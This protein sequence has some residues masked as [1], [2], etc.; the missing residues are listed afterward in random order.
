MKLG[1]KI[2]RDI[3]SAMINL[4]QI[5]PDVLGIL[6]RSG[7]GIANFGFV[8]AKETWPTII[9]Y[10]EIN[11]QIDQL[12]TQ[13]SQE[14][15]GNGELKRIKAELLDGD[16][17]RVRKIAEVVKQGKCILFLGPGALQFN[18]NGVLS[19][20][21]ESL[22]AQLCI[23]LNSPS[24]IYYDEA[25]KKDLRYIVQRYEALP[26][27]VNGEIGAKAVSHFQNVQPRIL[28][29]PFQ[30][31]KMM[32]FKLIINTNADDSF[33]SVVNTT[34]NSLCGNDYYDFSNDPEN[35]HPDL[36]K[37]E[38]V[39][40]NI[41]GSLKYPHSILFT[42]ADYVRFSKNILQKTPPL[43]LRVINY[44]DDSQYYL[45]LVFQFSAWHL[46]ILMEALSIVKKDERSVSVY[47]DKPLSHHE[48]EYY[49][50]EF[51]FHFLDYDVSEFTTI[52]W[53]EYQKI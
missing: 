51:K 30:D 49:D 31:L 12:I 43:P 6:K 22:A 11:Q 13:A 19:T 41:F 10:A 36:S 48:F 52:L 27:Y 42:E 24:G 33:S 50:K 28:D 34:N 1:P 35:Q 37:F 45:F 38:K 23:K 5:E 44:F 46:K 20:F 29:R 26:G 7:I 53:R 40:Y 21:N 16:L 39:E 32:N 9:E 8:S 15:D 25:L 14:N 17:R 3:N 2:I 18:A 4:Y 47:I